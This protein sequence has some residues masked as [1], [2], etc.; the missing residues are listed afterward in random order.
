MKGI[1]A[2]P[3]PATPRLLD[4][5]KACR[6]LGR[7]RIL[8]ADDGRELTPKMVKRWVMQA[9]RRAGLPETGRMHIFRHT[10]ASHLAMAGVPPKTVQEL[11]RHRSL[12]AT[13]RYMH[14][15][16]SAKD[17]GIDMLVRCRAEGGRAV[18]AGAS[19][20]GATGGATMARHA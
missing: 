3:V 12:A 5:L 13:M 7:E 6:G 9:E 18:A 1:D 20:G 16:P 8:T 10:F 4:A 17:E 2:K 19:L 14:L 11:A 15:S